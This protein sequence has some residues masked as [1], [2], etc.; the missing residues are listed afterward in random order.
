MD[1]GYPEGW[2][3]IEGALER[4]FR[5]PDFARAMAFVVRVAEVAEAEDHHPDIEIHWNRVKLRFWTHSRDA[6]TER[7]RDLA[8][9]T[10]ALVD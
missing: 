1:G 6:I 3:E 2:Q 9:L 7:D 4:V 10:A 5:F 8:R